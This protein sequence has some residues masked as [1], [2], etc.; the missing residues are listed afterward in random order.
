LTTEIVQFKCPSCGNVLGEEE[1]WHACEKS[2][3]QIAEGVKERL[4]IA[5]EKIKQLKIEHGKELIQKDEKYKIDAEKEANRRVT[6][7]LSEERMVMDLKHNQEL[8]E[9]EKTQRGV[10]SIEVTKREP[11]R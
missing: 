6:K 1:Y 8:A 4:R 11:Y 7:I 3:W 5:E 2:E 9:R 10:S